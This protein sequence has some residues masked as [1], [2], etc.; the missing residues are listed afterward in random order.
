MS[1]ITNAF[2]FFSFLFLVAGIVCAP[3][4]GAAGLF[5]VGVAVYFMLVSTNAIERGEK[6][7]KRRNKR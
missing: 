7:G 4:N 1:T 6:R 2:V 3:A 5:A